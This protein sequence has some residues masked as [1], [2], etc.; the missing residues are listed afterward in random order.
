MIEMLMS[1][2]LTPNFL[3]K[4]LTL[5]GLCAGAYL[6]AFL[7]RWKQKDPAV[8]VYFLLT[9]GL[10][11]R[12]TAGQIGELYGWRPEYDSYLLL[13]LLFGC[14]PFILG[15]VDFKLKKPVLWKIIAVLALVQVAFLCG[16]VVHRENTSNWIVP[17][18]APADLVGP[19]TP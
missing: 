11:F 14:T 5:A 19:Q 12:I 2:W 3:A 10:L 15:W 4:S 6:A 9:G 8:S 1:V 18:P 7:W 13:W 16:W 17:N